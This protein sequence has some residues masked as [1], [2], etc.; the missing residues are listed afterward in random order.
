MFHDPKHPI[1]LVLLVILCLFVLSLQLTSNPGGGH[2][3][4]RQYAAPVVIRRGARQKSKKYGLGN[5]YVKCG[6]F[7]KIWNQKSLTALRNNIA[8]RFVL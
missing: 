5:I 6:A 8:W 2:I 4:F 7:G 1:N 3:G